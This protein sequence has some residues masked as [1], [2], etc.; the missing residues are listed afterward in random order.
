M[1]IVK[2]LMWV[3]DLGFIAYWSLIITNTI[4]AALMF[5]G[6][7]DPYVQAWNW[8][9]FPLDIAASITGLIALLNVKLTQVMTVVSLTLTAI[10]GGMAIA[11]WAFLGYFDLSWWLPNLFLFAFGV[12]ALIATARTFNNASSTG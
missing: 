7:E 8:S 3:I 11:F 6:Y 5:E 1:R 10:A 4:P 12:I 9:F 2:L